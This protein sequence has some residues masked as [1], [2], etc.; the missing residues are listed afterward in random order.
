MSEHTN[1]AEMT[2]QLGEFLRD[3][4]LQ[5]GF[6]C[7]LYVTAASS[8]GSAYILSYWPGEQGLEPQLVASRHE[9]GGFKLPIAL[10]VVS[11]NAE[12]AYMRIERTGES[13]VVTLN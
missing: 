8:N 10:V 12:A 11:A 5:K 13:N 7:P 1:L 6:A 4:I 2:E 3:C 9:E